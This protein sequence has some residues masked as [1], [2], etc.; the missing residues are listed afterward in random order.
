[1]KNYIYKIFILISLL[2]FI[3]CEDEDK[4]PIPDVTNASIV[5]MTVTNQ[6]VT[7]T[8]TFTQP[9][10]AEVI[11]SPNVVSYTIE[12]TRGTDTVIFGEYN[13][14]TLNLNINTQ[15]IADAFSI[16]V[17][18]L[19]PNEVIS[20]SGSTIDNNGDVTTIDDFQS[21]FFGGDALGIRPIAY[22]FKIQI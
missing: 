14:F 10:N 7:S 5:S 13:S 16:Q 8:E 11:A 19:N 18:D 20:F 21:F 4:A 9:F 3:S 22:R 12:A 1:M 15:N 2:F 6:E 17:T